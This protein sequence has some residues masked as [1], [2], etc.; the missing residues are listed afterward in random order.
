ME[1]TKK[2][3]LALVL[4]LAAV[5]S[6]LPISA[7]A[8]DTVTVYCTPPEDWEVCRIYWWGSDSDPSWPGRRMRVN[9]DGVYYYDVPSNAQGL[10]FNNGSGQQTGDLQVPQ[11]EYV[12]YLVDNHC[13]V[14][15][16][17]T[18]PQVLYIVAG[19]DAL[20]GSSWDPGDRNNQMTDEDGDGIYTKTYENVAAGT[21]ELKVTTGS[22][23][24]SWGDPENGSNYVLNV[25][26]DGT[27]VTVAFDSEAK[28]ILIY[29]DGTQ[30]LPAYTVSGAVSGSF[31]VT[32]SGNGSS[33]TKTCNGSYKFEGITAG[34]YTLTFS[35]EGY[36]TRTYE[37]NM[38]D[39]SLVLD[40]T[41]H[42]QG[43]VNGDSKVNI[44]DTARVYAH[45]RGSS[46]LT[47]YAL[48]CADYSGDGTVNV[49]DTAKLYAYIRS[50]KPPVVTPPEDPDTPDTPDV[51]DVPDTP[52][53]PDVPD[54]PDT[55]INGVY[56]VGED[57]LPYTDEEIY[58]Q[59]FD[60]N[61]KLEIDLQMSDKELQK[62]Q[63]DYERYRDMGS[64]SPIYRMGT[65]TLTV[66][67]KNGTVSYVIK[68]VGARMKGNTSRT[69]FYNSSE[70]IYKYIHFKFDFQETFDDEE[71][72]GSDSKVWAS[73]EL[74]DE[75][76]D[77]TFAGLEKLEMR[78]NK[79][80]DSTY[81]R[82]SY[83]YEIF[84]SEGVLAPQCNIG[85]LTWSGARM[86]I[87]TVEE[88]VD[89][90]FINR[91]VP[92]ADQGGDLYKLG[93]TS[94]GATFTNTN[95]IGAEDE[96]KCKFYVYD[97]KTN[98]KKTD[99]SALL[100][101]INTLN[102]GKVTKDSFASVV[103]VDNFLR[104]AAVSYF[105]G[106]PDDLR[107]NYNNCYVYFLKSSGKAVFIPYD[108][109]RCLGINREWNPNG[110]SMTRD[111]PYG[112]GNQQSPLFRYSVD[113]GGFYTEEYTQVL[114]EVSENELLK[115]ES[116]EAR[117]N[118]AKSLYSN[119]VTP[120][121]NLKNAEGRD[122]SF[123]INRG[124]S[125]S[126]GDNMSFK[127]YINAKMSAFRSYMGI[128]DP[129][130][131]SD[132]CYILGDFNNWSVA[133]DYAM[134]KSGSLLTYTLRISNTGKFKVYDNQDGTWMGSECITPET[135]VSYETDHRTNIILGSGTWK[136]TYD[137]QI[138]KITIT[139][140]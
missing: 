116:F 72:Y 97:I 105:M 131:S 21:Y 117:F 43:D 123:D 137:P 100:N 95:S 120:E 60:P 56:V 109:D 85:A 133:G 110:N 55:P 136:I 45:I 8:A 90:L 124:G 1:I 5:I 80:Y 47:E 16:G 106:N 54:V 34:S 68:E 127:D 9:Q 35:A 139:Q 78:W 119:L 92:E 10:L 135:T 52:D 86:G 27:D 103:D 98:K 4:C 38:V 61:T 81:L 67:T 48:V 113:K 44:G 17:E 112:N 111:D 79:L 138:R 140:T 36:V 20:C 71:Y 115:P 23:A 53:V 96:D 32:L 77:R 91:N 29:M 2:R 108:F 76:K 24:Q 73:D 14:A 99:H 46:V 94:E 134:T 122:F 125:A 57:E 6:L 107:N 25:V 26:N 41:M 39:H 89:E 15:Y 30:P 11:D 3:I 88:P 62:L 66:T 33:V 101:L 13:W 42:L 7:W 74:R 22:W 31:Q 87:F 40:A 118:I 83:A 12:Q 114:L 130:P 19:F 129:T 82:E 37:L 126:G 64:K 69:S 121:R 132:N 84:R 59:I 93:W 70:G 28:K 51:P 128:T 75:R 49:G 63:D 58:Q 65:L 18:D 104:F 102:N 50:Q